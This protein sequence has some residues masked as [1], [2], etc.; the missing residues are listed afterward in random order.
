MTDPSNPDYCFGRR[1][2]L[3]GVAGGA[4]ATTFA[5]GDIVEAATGEADLS[6]EIYPELRV[7]KASALIAGEPIA[8]AYPLKQQPNLL[9]KLGA[10]ARRGVGPDRDIVAFSTLCPHM[11]GPLRG[12]YRHDSKALGPCPMHFSVFDLTKGGIPVHAQ[13]TQN[14]PQIVLRLDGNDIVA[15]GVI[16]LIYG[17]RNNL[18]GGGDEPFGTKSDKIKPLGLTDAEIDDV[19]AFLD[20]LSGTEIIVERP[21]SPPYGVLKFPMENQW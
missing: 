10:Q 9:V 5:P 17:Q 7:A 11:G 18:E 14:L 20:S 4:L 21:K 6:R 12:R 13:A 15:V 3:K 8:F 2:A 1:L 19:V 16:G